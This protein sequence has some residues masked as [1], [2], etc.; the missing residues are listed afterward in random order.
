MYALHSLYSPPG[1]L[2][3]SGL[4]V[5]YSLTSIHTI[6]TFLP[7]ASSHPSLIRAS[8]HPPIYLGCACPFQQRAFCLPDTKLAEIANERD[9]ETVLLSLIAI[10]SAKAMKREDFI[11]NDVPESIDFLDV[12]GVIAHLDECRK[13]GIRVDLTVKYGIKKNVEDDVQEIS[14]AES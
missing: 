2:Q 6:H 13:K 11:K 8:P 4:I 5:K 9:I 14:D 1:R 3:R 10:T 7:C 12:E